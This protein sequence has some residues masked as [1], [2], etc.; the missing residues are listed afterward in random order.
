MEVAPTVVSIVSVLLAM[1][2]V[3][4]AR[5]ATAEVG[6]SARLARN[7]AGRESADVHFRLDHISRHR[8]V[9]R[10][11]GTGTAFGVLVDVGE[12]VLHEGSVRFNE[13]RPG[14]AERYMLIQPLEIRVHEV[15]V[16]W[17]DRPD[18]LDAPRIARLPLRAGT[19][20]PERQGA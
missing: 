3:W 1:G 18:G 12:I 8:Y 4:Y 5:R 20:R 19:S 14:H 15:V 7:L 13:F 11:D 17:H 10:N 16:M 6:R 9:L 2:A